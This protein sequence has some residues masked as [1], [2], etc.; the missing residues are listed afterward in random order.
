MGVEAMSETAGPPFQCV[1]EAWTSHEREL[2]AFLLG[3]VRNAALADDLLQEVFL[4]ALRE[5][6]GFCRLDSPR[7]WLFQVTRHALIDQHRVRKPTV[8]V[9]EALPAPEAAIE[10]IDD[11]AQCLE[12]ALAA[13]DADDREVVQRCDL[14]GQT[15]RAYADANGLS[16]PAVKARIQ[17]ARVRLRQHL[18][19]QC[20]VR[21]DAGGHVCCH[22]FCRLP[23]K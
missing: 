4:K 18:V 19:D 20:G 8:P 14:E 17:R 6:V 11:L 13:L 23:R 10:P 3:Q 1:L 5:G 22:D 15:Q 9:L 7:A 16:L 2:H 12:R 21:F